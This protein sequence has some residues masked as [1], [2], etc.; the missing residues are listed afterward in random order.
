MSAFNFP[1]GGLLLVK[2]TLYDVKIGPRRSTQP[3]PAAK[4]I[5][6]GGNVP[7]PIVLVNSWLNNGKLGC[8][9]AGRTLPDS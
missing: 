5:S 8:F 6:G 2:I 7:R 9:S 3:L 1:L 4:E